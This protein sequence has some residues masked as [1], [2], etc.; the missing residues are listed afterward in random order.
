MV[1]TILKLLTVPGPLLVTVI[2]YLS[3]EPAATVVLPSVLN[4]D[5][6]TC[7]GTATNPASMVRSVW[8]AVSEIAAVMPVVALALESTA[9][10]APCVA[11]VKL[12]PDGA[13]N[14][15]S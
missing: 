2:V 3:Q 11:R 5:K 10:F 15:T 9:P 7:C 1:S 12:S 14:C 4:T 8:P 13:T 6:S